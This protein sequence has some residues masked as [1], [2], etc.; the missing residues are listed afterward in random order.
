MQSKAKSANGKVKGPRMD[1]L[2]QAIDLRRDDP[3]TSTGH[4]D[5]MLSAPLCADTNSSTQ[6]SGS[7][8]SDENDNDQSEYS[9]DARVPALCEDVEVETCRA[10]KLKCSRHSPCVRCV[11]LNLVCTP[12]PVVQRG[13]PSHQ[14]RLAQMTNGIKDHHNGSH[15]FIAGTM[16]PSL[17]QPVAMPNSVFMPQA[18]FGSQPVISALPQGMHLQDP[19][20]NPFFPGSKGL[21]VSSS[22]QHAPQCGSTSAGHQML[23]QQQMEARHQ[24]LIQQQQQQQ[25]V[26]QPQVLLHSQAH[27]N[28]LAAGRISTRLEWSMMANAP[29]AGKEIV[30]EVINMEH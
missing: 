7:A 19:L 9:H 20:R 27:M 13:R 24:L 26:V 11:R 4:D 2:L 10:A 30:Q 22:T 17:S 1:A 29:L 5:P 16:S 25:H 18:N 12:P 23:M 8:G 21:Q 3:P 6:G 14:A 28:P 15:D